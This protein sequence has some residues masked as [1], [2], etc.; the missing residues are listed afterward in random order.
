MKRIFTIALASLGLAA[1]TTPAQKSAEEAHS[2]K[3]LV[4]YYSQTGATKKVAEEIKQQLNAEIAEIVAEHP[5]DGN[6]TET[7]E[8]CKKEMAAGEIPAVKPL[9]VNIKNYDQIFL[10]FPVWFGTYAPP[11]AAF[12]QDSSLAGKKIITFCTYGS[13][14]LQSSTDSLKKAL[15][16]CEIVEGYGVRNARLDKA[17]EELNRFLIE[18]GYKEGEIEA[19]PAF[20][21]HHPVTP[22]EGRIFNEACGNYQFPLGTPVDVAVRETANSTDYEFTAESNSPTGEDVKLKSTIYVTVEKTEGATPVFT[23]VIR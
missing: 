22:E 14:G 6:F 16:N 5:Y 21:E 18:W 17:A 9:N 7:I 20:M 4:V 15:P 13:G 3:T 23:Q 2:P 11:V 19:L 12:I 1:C 10:G 8:R